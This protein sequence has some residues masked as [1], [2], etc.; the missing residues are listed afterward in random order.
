MAVEIEPYFAAEA[1]KRRKE[2]EGRPS[3][4]V[5]NVPPVSEKAKSRDQAAERL[6]KMSHNL[7]ASRSPLRKMS[8]NGKSANHKS[9]DQ[10]AAEAIRHGNDRNPKN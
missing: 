2:T 6:W 7:K 4:L 8:L 9:R 10:A 5:E 3:K 1:A